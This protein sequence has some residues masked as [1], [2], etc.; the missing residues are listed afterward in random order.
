MYANNKA[1]VTHEVRLFFLFLTVV[2]CMTK[3]RI[4]VM[5]TGLQYVLWFIG[6]REKLGINT[7]RVKQNP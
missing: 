4:V 5:K 3:K 1:P 6:M 2:G 7:E